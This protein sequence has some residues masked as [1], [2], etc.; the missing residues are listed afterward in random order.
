MVESRCGICCSECQG[1]EQVHCKG[2]VNMERPFWGGECPVK[3]C[4]EEKNL[5]HCGEC[6]DFPCPTLEDMG[7][8]EG[9]DSAPKI[10]QCREWSKEAALT[11]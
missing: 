4:C 11:E 10:A 9:Y 3:S 2:C 1:K 8:E 6:P 5:F 7:K